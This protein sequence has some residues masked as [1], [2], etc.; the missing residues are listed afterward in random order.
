MNTKRAF[1]VSSP[2]LTRDTIA[3]QAAEVKRRQEGGLFPSARCR[4]SW[5]LLVFRIN[6][7]SAV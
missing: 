7:E 5:K 3:P 6:R 4:E 2:A 1:G